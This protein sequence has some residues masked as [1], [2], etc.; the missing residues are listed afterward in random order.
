MC[1]DATIKV[2]A[3]TV[4]IH[5]VAKPMVDH[6][7]NDEVTNV[8]F[9]EESKMLC[10]VIVRAT[11]ELYTKQNRERVEVV[12]FLAADCQNLPNS[13]LVEKVIF[14]SIPY[15]TIIDR[16]IS[17]NIWSTDTVRK[18]MLM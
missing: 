15:L 17:A 11:D 18:S 13:Q 10:H 6:Q 2:K 12:K 1:K 5:D 9:D 4:E 3:A 14:T 16:L 8:P 7:E